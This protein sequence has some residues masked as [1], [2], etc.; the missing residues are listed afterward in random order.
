[1]IACPQRQAAA[2]RKPVHSKRVEGRFIAAQTACRSRFQFQSFVMELLTLLRDQFQRRDS[3]YY[4][5]SHFP[6]WYAA[7]A[8]RSVSKTQ[9]EAEEQYSPPASPCFAPLTTPQRNTPCAPSI[10]QKNP[11][12]IPGDFP[13]VSVNTFVSA[14]LFVRR[15]TWKL[16]LTHNQ[17]T[18]LPGVVEL[19]KCFDD[20]Y[21]CRRRR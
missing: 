7:P 15:F 2:W 13:I 14:S 17:M 9:G 18:A 6:P 8:V 3:L 1:M 11:S 16:L 10:C 21:A 12:E 19:P 5:G 4:A 20:V